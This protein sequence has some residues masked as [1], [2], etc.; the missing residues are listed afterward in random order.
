MDSLKIAMDTVMQK[1]LETSFEYQKSFIVRENELMELKTA[2][3]IEGGKPFEKIVITQK[4]IDK[5]DTLFKSHYPTKILESYFLHFQNDR[6]KNLLVLYE[7]KDEFFKTNVAFLDA[8]NHFLNAL[9]RL[10]KN[11]TT[12]SLWINNTEVKRS[13]TISN[14]KSATETWVIRDNRWLLKSTE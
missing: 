5:V 11:Q 12:D 14:S 3:Y 13:Y 1:N 9:P 2:S 4:N 10:S 8:Q 6:E 7:T